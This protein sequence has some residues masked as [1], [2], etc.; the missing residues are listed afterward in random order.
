MYILIF[1]YRSDENLRYP[2]DRKRR[3]EIKFQEVMLFEFPTRKG[4]W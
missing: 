4:G 2:T 1:F 3:E